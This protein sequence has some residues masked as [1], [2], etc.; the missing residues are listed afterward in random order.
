MKQNEYLGALRAALIGIGVGMAVLLLG[1]LL[2]LRMAD[3]R[4]LLASIAYTALVLGGAVSGFLEGRAGASRPILG[5]TAGI[6][7][8]LLL[9][10]SLVM[11][12]FG[13]LWI[14]AAVYLL[15]ALIT[16]LVGWLTP[17]ARPKRKYRYK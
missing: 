16:L 3:P 2:A 6:Y 13:R 15:M 14:K 1:T 11:G 12:G 8:G 17:S 5:L 10:I 4:A 7:S 9:I